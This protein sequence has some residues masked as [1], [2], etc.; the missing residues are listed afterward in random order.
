MIVLL[1]LILGPFIGLIGLV[2]FDGAWSGLDAEIL[3]LAWLLGAVPAGLCGWVVRI[4]KLTRGWMG[5]VAAAF[6]GAACG[7][8]FGTVLFRDLEAGIVFGS[9]G[10]FSALVLSVFL[11][12]EKRKDT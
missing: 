7:A 4:A 6:I 8:L 5:S 9:C 1:F 12:P 3:L 10:A 2:W 11:P